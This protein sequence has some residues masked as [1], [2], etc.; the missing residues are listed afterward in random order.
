MAEH[1]SR[2]RRSGQRNVLY[3]EPSMMGVVV[4]LGVTAAVIAIILI[5]LFGDLLSAD[6]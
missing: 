6:Y 3:N 2:R 5:V 4:A 1:G